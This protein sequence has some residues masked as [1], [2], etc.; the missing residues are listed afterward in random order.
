M[1]A[2]HEHFKSKAPDLHENYSRDKEQEILP[3]NTAETKTT[4]SKKLLMNDV[5]SRILISIVQIFDGNA[6]AQRIGRG[7]S[8]HRN[9]ELAVCENLLRQVDAD[10]AQ[11]LTLRLVDRHGKARANRKL[12]T[13]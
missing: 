7:N 12:P 11:R 5:P 4:H 9:V 13:T 10:E 2:E 3:H 8:R 6:D 1:T